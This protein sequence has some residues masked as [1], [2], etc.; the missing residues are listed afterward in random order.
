VAQLYRL[1]DPANTRKSLTQLLALLHVLDCEVKFVI[2]PR[3]AA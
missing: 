2:N 1:L 3:T